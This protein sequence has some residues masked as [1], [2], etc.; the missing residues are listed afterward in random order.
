MKQHQ[1]TVGHPYRPTFRVIKGSKEQAPEIEQLTNTAWN[2]A[3]TALW[4]NSVFSKTEI[5]EAK[6]CIQQFLLTAKCPIKAY[7]AFCQR[8]LLARQYVTSQP[9]RFIP[10]PTIWLDKTNASGFAGTREWYRNILAVRSSLPNF[11]TELKAFAE[12]ILEMS[13][14]GTSKNFHFWRNY[15]IDK[16]TPG[17][18]SLFL[19]TVANQQF[20]L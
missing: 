14:E 16:K 5:E 12:A 2:F 15:F 6:K 7:K 9:N 11:K 4:N 17:L 1:F 20:E 19:N 3:F 13:E 18:L 8:V 10:L